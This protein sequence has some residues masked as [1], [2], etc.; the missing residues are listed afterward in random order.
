MSNAQQYLL[1]EVVAQVARLDLKARF[2]VEGFISGL[3]ASPFHGFSV[4]FSEHRKYEPGDEVSTID[5][6][7]WG[8]TD[9]YY[10]KKY[11]AETNA[12]C[13]L[14]VDVSPSMG[15]RYAGMTKLEYA[16]TLAAAL[17]LIMIGQQDP[18]GLITFD[19]KVKSV[20]QPRSKRSQL[21][22]L[23][24]E[25]SKVT[26]GEQT[27]V[28]AA[29]HEVADIVRHRGFVMIFSD[30]LADRDRALDGLHHLAFRKHDLI[31]FHILDAAEAKFPF[32][33]YAHF[34][35]VETGETVT[36]DPQAVRDD[37]LARVREF[38]EGYR[39]ACSDVRVDFVSVDTST[40][41][42]KALT[43]FLRMRTEGR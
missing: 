17:A 15:H 28:G 37:Y 31:L 14:V 26:P 2:I 7:L 25:L 29:L 5:W 35:D 9:R 20:V 8:R 19:R 34:E 12:A 39:K 1:P 24:A 23:L 4:E 38:I 21:P 40:P 27:D 11:K 33:E 16:T 30:L 43:S 32:E 3:H 18:V 41:F 10:V 36:A 13:H 42:D 6:G 22:L